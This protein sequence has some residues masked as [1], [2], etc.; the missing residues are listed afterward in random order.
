VIS[1]E[2]TG[3]GMDA[4]DKLGSETGAGMD[5]IEQ[6][7]RVNRI[8][9]FTKRVCNAASELL[10]RCYSRDKLGNDRRRDGCR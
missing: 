5:T 6:S 9:V 8:V 3:A 7:A 1:L 4:V 2:T 10:K